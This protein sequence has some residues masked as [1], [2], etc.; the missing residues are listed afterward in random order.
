ME[1]FKYCIWFKPEKE[2]EWNKYTN[3]FPIHMTI[4]SKLSK[5]SLKDFNNIIFLN[6]KLKVKLVGN[7]YQT[8]LN[9]FYSLQYNIVPINNEIPTWWPFNAHISF[10]YQYSKEFNDNEIKELDNII[11]TKEGLLD[12]IS[13]YKCR[14][15]FSKWKKYIYT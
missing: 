13:V 2:H 8:K 6:K 12:T 10:K 7:L 1:D 5:S 11:K 3:E 4:K 14:G 15:H 9:N